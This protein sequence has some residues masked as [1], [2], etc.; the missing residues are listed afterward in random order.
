M[1]F[2]EQIFCI[3]RILPLFIRDCVKKQTEACLSALLNKQEA[4]LKI[5]NG[6]GVLAF[7]CMKSE[8]TNESVCHLCSSML[9]LGSS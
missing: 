8:L 6:L 2:H 4:N 5:S 9:F 1:F 3:K 7:M